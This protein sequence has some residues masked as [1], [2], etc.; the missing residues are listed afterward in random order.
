MFLRDSL[1]IVIVPRLALSRMLFVP[2]SFLD[3]ETVARDGKTLVDVMGDACSMFVLFKCVDV[4][5]TL[6]PD[7]GRR[8]SS[9]MQKMCH[10]LPPRASMS[11]L[12]Q[13]D[14]QLAMQGRVHRRTE[15]DVA[16]GMLP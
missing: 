11:Q 10:E 6:L 9:K 5:A 8:S 13:S 12:R 2:R 3:S 15:G 7:A 16:A 14:W 1:I 4:D